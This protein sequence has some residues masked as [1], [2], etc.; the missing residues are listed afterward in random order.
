MKDIR[1]WKRMVI[2]T[3]ELKRISDWII[4]GKSPVILELK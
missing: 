2:L 4:R 3:G 1:L